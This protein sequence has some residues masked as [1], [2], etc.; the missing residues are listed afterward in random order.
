MKL[1]WVSSRLRS[2]AERRW[3]V[4]DAAVAQGPG[5]GLTEGAKMIKR[6]GGSDA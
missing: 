3:E 5:L 6:A 1:A 4:E 2:G